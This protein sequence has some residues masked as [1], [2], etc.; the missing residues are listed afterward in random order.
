MEHKYT[1]KQCKEDMLKM[2]KWLY[3][4]PIKDKDDFLEENR[5]FNQNLRSNCAC[6]EFDYEIKP[7]DKY[8]CENCPVDW[9]GVNQYG[10]S[11]CTSSS[12]PYEKW[13]NSN[14][15]H[16]TTRM[17]YAKEVYK[18]ALQIKVSDEK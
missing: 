1:L 2:W 18:L 4:N 13:D 11:E 9:W 5:D 8:Q 7:K 10:H 6:C 12:S 3:E 14:R 15:Y 16:I 17:I